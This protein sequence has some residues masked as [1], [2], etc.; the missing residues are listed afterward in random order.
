[1]THILFLCMLY[2]LHI[3]LW[4]WMLHDV[5]IY[6]LFTLWVF[7]VVD[8]PLYLF[9]IFFVFIFVLSSLPLWFC[10]FQHTITHNCL[11]QKSHHIMPYHI[12]M[13]KTGTMQQQNQCKVRSVRPVFHQHCIWNGSGQYSSWL[14]HQWHWWVT[15]TAGACWGRSSN[16][17]V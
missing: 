3:M 14:A 5:I 4:C 17:P 2:M 10:P 16:E 15:E 13:A 6:S 11:L 9:L 7:L 12:H 1:M 8:V